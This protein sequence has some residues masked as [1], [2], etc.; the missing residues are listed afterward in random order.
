MKRVLHLSYLICLVLFLCDLKI[1]SGAGLWLPASSGIQNPCCPPGQYYPHLGLV[2]EICTEINECGVDECTQDC[3]PTGE[4]EAACY[5]S[6]GYWNDQTCVCTPRCNDD[7]RLACLGKTGTWDPIDCTCTCDL[8]GERRRA[9]ES[10]YGTWDDVNCVCNPSTCD[11]NKRSHCLALGFEWIEDGCIC[12]GCEDD[13]RLRCEN[14]GGNWSWDSCTCIIYQHCDAQQRDDCLNNGGTWTD[15]PDCS[16]TYQCDQSM[17]DD[18]LNHGGGWTDWPSCSCDYCA[19]PGPYELVNV[20]SYSSYTCVDCETAESCS[21][22]WYY[23]ESYGSDGQTV[24]DSYSELF[25]DGCF[26][27]D[28][29]WCFYD[30]GCD[31]CYPFCYED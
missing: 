4:L 22:A 8:T 10:Q 25:D 11:A 24:C 16:C 18:C 31:I 14:E 1:V 6:Y 12:V 3:D 9:C 23:Y 27:E 21:W 13:D 30:L 28:D 5:A 15:Y 2:G 20:D 7:D 29:S 17:K 26:Y 19:N